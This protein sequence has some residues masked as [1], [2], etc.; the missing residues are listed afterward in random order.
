MGLTFPLNAS[1]AG[2]QVSQNNLSV[3]L[4]AKNSGEDV[5]T[6]VVRNAFQDYQKAKLGLGHYAKKWTASVAAYGAVMGL[7][8]GAVIGTTYWIFK[9]Y[10][11]NPWSLIRDLAT[12]RPFIDPNTPIIG[13]LSFYTSPAF[14]VATLA[15]LAAIDQVFQKETGISPVKSVAKWSV[16][17][18]SS[19]ILY[20]S[21]KAGEMVSSSYHQDEEESNISK[22]LS[23]QKIID[24]LKCIYDHV[25]DGF[26]N[27][28]EKVTDNPKE[29]I[30]FKNMALQLEENLP[31]IKSKLAALDLKA[32]EIN[33]IMSRLCVSISTIK[34]SALEFRQ[35]R[36]DNN[37]QFNIDLLKTVPPRDISSI[38]IPNDV[39]NHLKIANYNNVDSVVKLNGYLEAAAKGIT[40]AVVTDLALA[41]FAS[42]GSSIFGYQG[43][44]PAITAV[45]GAIPSI[46]LGAEEANKV[47]EV[48]REEQVKA[49][50]RKA[51]QVQ[52][53]HEKLR[54]IYNGLADYFRKKVSESHYN[55]FAMDILKEEAK[56]IL[57]KLPLIDEEIAKVELLAN[58]HPVTENLRRLL[59]NLLA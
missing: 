43:N 36:S 18:M 45:V 54:G 41:L 28:Y 10:F 50:S 27:E 1:Q 16:N 23:H 57:A 38:A 5:T 6:E 52:I 25:A 11:N 17:M 49:E 15:G 56:V 40:V 39:K 24:E 35:T 29:M 32:F 44:L 42:F 21:Y 59:I 48:C 4:C 33:Q 34:E 13:G 30:R 31:Y 58:L 12:N 55:P 51:E 3:L 53:A 8:V 19:V 47:L 2:S 26:Y 20:A 9:D 37:I 46:K 7:P 22:K 14:G